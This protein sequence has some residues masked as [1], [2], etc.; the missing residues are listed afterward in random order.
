MTFQQLVP[1]LQA[2]VSPVVMISGVGLLIL[3]MTNRLARVVDRSRQIG[4]ARRNAPPADLPGLVSQLQT[5]VHRAR[6]LRRAIRFA[7]LC[8]LM[9]AL[10][11]IVIFLSACLGLNSMLPAVA[12]FIL[13]LTSLIVALISFIQDINLSLAA[14][15]TEL[16]IEDRR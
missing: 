6:L 4:T 12:I 10:L 16:G 2:A 14:L 1:I 5:L 15:H 7:T 13:C 3:S 9:A 11:V 8:V